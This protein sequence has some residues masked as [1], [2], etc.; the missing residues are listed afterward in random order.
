VALAVAGPNDEVGIHFV[1]WAFPAAKGDVFVKLI[2]G[3]V[4]STIQKRHYDIVVLDERV[5]AI[6]SIWSTVA[7]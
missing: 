5:A 4:L 6:Q 7:F 2:K 1:K 3:P